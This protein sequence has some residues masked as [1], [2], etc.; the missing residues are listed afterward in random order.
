MTAVSAT[1]APGQDTLRDKLVSGVL[2]AAG[3]AWLGGMLSVLMLVQL[4]VPADRVDWL[5]R[6]YCRGQVWLT[7]S[8]WRAVL[9]PDVDPDTPYLFVQNH[10]NHFDHVTCYPATP[11]FKQGIELEEHFGIPLYG[12][13]MKQR[14]TIGVSRGARGQLRKLKRA[15]AAEL[16][17]GHSLLAFPEGTRTLDGRVGTFHHGLLYLARELGVPIVPVAV[18]G[19]YAVMHKGSLLIRPGHEVTVY[20]EAPVPTEGLSKEDLPALAEQLHATISGRVD[21]WWASR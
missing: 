4:F 15:F 16:A 21:A 14:G 2:W 5:A 18:T 7:G 6:L 19:M 3:A 20:V 11:H 9:H 8:R 17:R 13:F 12:W 1:E 10:V